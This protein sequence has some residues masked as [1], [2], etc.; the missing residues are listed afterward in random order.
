MIR[1]H[2]A[3]EYDGQFKKQEIEEDDVDPRLIRKWREN[4]QSQTMEDNTEEMSLEM[5]LDA[6]RTNDSQALPNTQSNRNS[7]IDSFDQPN[8]FERQSK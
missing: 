3:E 5:D 4:D 7:R 8:G 6:Y 1:Q 2:V